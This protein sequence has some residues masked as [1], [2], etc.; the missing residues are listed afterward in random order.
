[1][2]YSKI[3]FSLVLS[4]MPLVGMQKKATNACMAYSPNSILYQ[5]YASMPGGM[6]ILAAQAVAHHPK[7]SPIIDATTK[8]ARQASF[9][10]P[11]LVA[12]NSEAVKNAVMGQLPPMNPYFS[13]CI[14]KGIQKTLLYGGVSVAAYLF[15]TQT[16]GYLSKSALAQIFEPIKQKVKNVRR[17]AEIDYADTLDIDQKIDALSAQVKTVIA[18]LKDYEKTSAAKQESITLKTQAL[19]SI[20]QANAQEVIA[21]Q[22]LIAQINIPELTDAVKRIAAQ[23]QETAQTH[24]HKANV[25]NI[26]INGMAEDVDTLFNKVLTL[27]NSIYVAQ[28]RIEHILELAEKIKGQIKGLEQMSDSA[29]EFSGDES[30]DEDFPRL[31]SGSGR[32]VRLA[33]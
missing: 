4:C 24:A 6:W 12:Y 23:I 31:P 30:E 13:V 29:S 16:L 20:Q 26:L 32:Q 21:L 3:I 11:A 15:Y 27:A 2:N 17:L 9:I 10:V 33:F 28:A 19:K 22:K 5:N 18:S 25:N 14:D 8:K 1:M 7:I